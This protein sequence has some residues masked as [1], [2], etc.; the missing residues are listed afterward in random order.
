MAKL[1]PVY[2]PGGKKV[3]AYVQPEMKKRRRRR[4]L[5]KAKKPKS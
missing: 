4:V 2:G 3:V 1:I 5:A